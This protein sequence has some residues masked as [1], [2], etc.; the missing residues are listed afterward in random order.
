M[1]GSSKDGMDIPLPNISDSDEDSL[2]VKISQQSKVLYESKLCQEKCEAQ[3]IGL[4]TKLGVVKVMKKGRSEAVHIGCTPKASTATGAP[5]IPNLNQPTPPAGSPN[6]LDGG[7]VCKKS[8]SEQSSPD[9]DTPDTT[10]G[11]ALPVDTRAV[12]SPTS[13][14]FGIG[15]RTLSLLTFPQSPTT[16]NCRGVVNHGYSFQEELHV[17]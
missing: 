12:L 6:N 8:K 15:N 11:R 7:S 10:A 5:T 9:G 1:A 13:P 2:T 16:T 3:L 14:H 4:N 17:I